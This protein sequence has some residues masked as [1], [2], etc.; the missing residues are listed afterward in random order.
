[1]EETKKST[2]NEGCGVM[3]FFFSLLAIGYVIILLP[4]IILI[5]GF[6]ISKENKFW[7][8][9]GII[10]TEIYLFFDL[11]QKWVLSYLIYGSDG[12]GKNGYPDLLDV[13]VK[14]KDYVTILYIICL[15]LALLFIIQ[16]Y[17]V[18]KD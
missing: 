11:K 4:L 18:R 3:I 9:I 17:L 13:F 5:W 6:F 15:L 2:N 12:N 14:Y 16:S 8:G 7:N 10:T 1:M